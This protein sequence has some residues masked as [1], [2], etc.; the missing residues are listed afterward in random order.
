ME[1]SKVKSSC[2]WIEVNSEAPTALV[3][4]PRTNRP[5]REVITQQNAVIACIEL[6]MDPIVTTP[7]LTSIASQR[8]VSEKQQTNM[9]L[10]TASE[11]HWFRFKD[12]VTLW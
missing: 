8:D 3:W 11:N 4:K 6:P 10:R 12:F 1:E 2:N 7:R 9:S 5:D